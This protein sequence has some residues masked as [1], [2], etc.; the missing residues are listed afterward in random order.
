MRILDQSG[1]VLDTWAMHHLCSQIKPQTTITL[2][3]CVISLVLT[4]KFVNK[5]AMEEEKS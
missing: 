3:F 1:G 4:A 5:M 2:R